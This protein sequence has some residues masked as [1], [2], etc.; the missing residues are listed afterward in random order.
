MLYHVKAIFIKISHFS[1]VE[2]A[3]FVETAPIYPLIVT[4]SAAL[5]ALIII[6][7]S[8]TVYGIRYTLYNDNSDD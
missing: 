8:R 6:P 3:T 1:G 4:Y 2:P 5:D 7:I